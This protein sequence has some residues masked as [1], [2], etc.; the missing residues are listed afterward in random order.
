MTSFSAKQIILSL[1]LPVALFAS[2][3][4]QARSQIESSGR[5]GTSINGGSGTQ[6]CISGVCAITGGTDAG[7]NKF[8][9]FTLFDANRTSESSISGVTIKTDSQ[10][11]IILGV[12]SSS[13]GFNLSVPLSLDSAANLFIVSPDGISLST[14][15]SFSNV[16][17][18]TL[19]NLSTLP[20]GSGQFSVNSSF[21]EVS[22]L[23]GTPFLN[24]STTSLTSTAPS[25]TISGVTLSVD[26]SLYV[27]AN[28]NLTVSSSTISAPVSLDVGADLTVSNSTFSYNSS[29]NSAVSLYS[30]GSPAINNTVLSG[31]S[32]VDIDAGVDLTISNSTIDNNTNVSL[33]SVRNQ[34]IYDSTI[35]G[36]SSVDIDAGNILTLSDQTSPSDTGVSISENTAVTIDSVSNFNIVNS[37]LDDNDALTITVGGDFDVDSI[38]SVSSSGVAI[39]QNTSLT[40]T[41]IG[42]FSY[43]RSSINDNQ[44]ITIDAGGDFVFFSSELLRNLPYTTAQYESDFDTVNALPVFTIDAAGMVDIDDS[45]IDFNGPFEMTSSTSDVLITN[46]DFLDNLY[47]YIESVT[48]DIDIVS[49]LLSRNAF[50]DA[51]AFGDAYIFDT[52]VVGNDLVIGAEQG[53]AVIVSSDLSGNVVSTFSTDGDAVIVDSNVDNNVLDVE[54]ESGD[55]VIVDSDVTDTD[56]VVVSTDGDSVIAD[57]SV[58]NTV[59]DVESE[60][61]DAAIADS[62]VI[63]SDVFAVSA[64]GDVVVFGSNVDESVFEAAALTG[65]IDVLNSEFVNNQALAFVADFDVSISESSVSGNELLVID[66]GNDAL[67][68]SSDVSGSDSFVVDA[69]NDVLIESSSMSDNDDVFID[70]G[71]NLSIASN[72]ESD[73][74]SVDINPSS[75][76]ENSGSQT[77]ASVSSSSQSTSQ[78]ASTVTSSATTDA[79]ADSNSDSSANS[80]QSGDSSADSESDTRSETA[81]DDATNDEGSSETS[82][83]SATQ[84]DSSDSRT[85]DSD[86][87]SGDAGESPAPSFQISTVDPNVAASN[88]RDSIDS[89]TAEVLST[90]GLD[91][92]SPTPASELTPARIAQ[93]LNDARQVYQNLSVSSLSHSAVPVASSASSQNLMISANTANAAFNPAFLNISFTKNADLG[94]GDSSKGF[95]DLTLITSDNTVIARRTELPLAEFATLLRGFYGKIT[96]QRSL[97][98]AFPSSEASRLYALFL[99]PVQDVLS[100]ENI[101]TVLVSADRGLQ[102]IPFSALARQGQYAVDNLSFSFTPSLSLTDLSIPLANPDL[103]EILIMG[104]T[105]FSGLAPLPYVNQEVQNIAQYYGGQSVLGERFTSSRAVSDLRSSSESLIHLATHADFKGGK[106]DESMIYT[107]DGSISFE[108]FKSIRRQRQANPINL[109]V[110]S[111]C[112]SALGDSD[113]EMGLAGMALQAGSKSAIGSLWYVDDVATSAFFSQFY[114]YLS[115]GVTKSTALTQTQRDFALGKVKIEGSDVVFGSGD[116]LLSGLSGS[117]KYNYPNDFTHPFF[118]SGFILLGTPW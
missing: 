63:G 23:T 102:A 72:L 74:G 111:A 110:L 91:D 101:S 90:L 3:S 107:S 76:V 66:V 15:A 84:D 14:G 58:V 24:R 113:S 38:A 96:S 56:V 4:Q 39:N 45:S 30:L 16:T 50:I 115:R 40:I 77:Q 108:D 33:A 64:E 37:N 28:S 60:T 61:G 106:P 53:D 59:V 20:I 27:H 114:R 100:T 29:G 54:S 68:D 80:E 2:G 86:S 73:N 51:Y 41:T 46:S 112:R 49:S 47:P 48:G 69:G 71:N 13:N 8:H 5:F 42:D 95:I 98:P 35:D 44:M 89:N 6:S 7:S 94:V 97:E 105:E 10:S 81:T 9:R 55:A 79:D 52:S 1:G 18:L 31:N 70:A 11:N 118:W 26:G 104:S 32:S 92:I 25:I 65:N 99:E 93:S 62:D 17:D 103:D 82:S 43:Y 117:Q 22:L 87:G 34:A 67:I 36:N 83:S 21:S 109:F 57:S 75:S 85:S 12:A 78:D 116:V 19:T 88:L